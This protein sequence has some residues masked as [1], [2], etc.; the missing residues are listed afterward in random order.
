[1]GTKLQGGARDGLRIHT[2]RCPQSGHRKIK[3]L[4]GGK[5]SPF[6]FR[7]QSGQESVT[8]EKTYKFSPIE[9]LVINL[10]AQSEQAFKSLLPAARRSLSQSLSFDSD[11]AWNA[12]FEVLLSIEER[13]EF[14]TNLYQSTAVGYANRAGITAEDG[15]VW[16]VTG[17]TIS[18][19]AA[20]AAD[21]LAEVAALSGAELLQHPDYPKLVTEAKN[22]F[23][24]AAFEFAANNP[25]KVSAG[26]VADTVA[27]IENFSDAAIKD[28]RPI[29]AG[30]SR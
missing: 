30:V 28:T 7:P 27:F 11:V 20:P 29:A 2:N 26:E 9:Q 15:E 23:R 5:L 17:D 10:N 6:Y 16:S 21:P 22:I 18:V 14:Y 13:V 1:M 12:A 19:L 4:Q 3:A 24:D 25:E 8:M